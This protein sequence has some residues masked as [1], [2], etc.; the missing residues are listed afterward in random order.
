MHVKMRRCAEQLFKELSTCI[1]PQA[2]DISDNI[3]TLGERRCVG[4]LLIFDHGEICIG[5]GK[6]LLTA[7]FREV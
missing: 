5:N 2:C 7:R 1:R 4:T 6:V 3:V